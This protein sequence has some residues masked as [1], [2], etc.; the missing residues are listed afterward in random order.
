[1]ESLANFCRRFFAACLAVPC[2]GWPGTLRAIWAF[3]LFFDC[4]GKNAL[5]AFDDMGHGALAADSALQ[6]A[7]EPAAAVE[8]AV[9]AWKQWVTVV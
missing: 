1:M 4:D 5:P 2:G 3:F 8:E 6:Y 7:A 9:R